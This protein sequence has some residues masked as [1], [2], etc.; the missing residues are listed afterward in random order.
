M[1]RALRALDRLIEREIFRLRARYQLS[2]DE[3]R[4]LYVS[5]EQVD[6]LVQEHRSARS[7][8]VAMDQAEADRV[9]QDFFQALERI[10]DVRWNR[11]C[12]VHAL[13]PLEKAL[14]FLA[15]APELDLKYETLL[16]YLNNDITRK[17]PTVDLARRVLGSTSRD[18]DAV[19]ASVASG[20]RLTRLHIIDPI[21]APSGSPSTLQAGF[22]LHRSAVRF[23]AG[24][25][26]HGADAEATAGRPAVAM[27]ATHAR[28]MSRPDAPVLLLAASGAE[29][30]DEFA[31]ALADTMG[32]P[33]RRFSLGGSGTHAERQREA[34]ALALEQ[35]LVPCV[36][37]VD[38]PSTIAD[39]ERREEPG[40]GLLADFGAPLLIRIGAG[41]AWRSLLN[42]R[43]TLKLTLRE[44]DFDEREALWAHACE[45][46]GLTLADE[47]VA[48][49]ADRYALSA[50]QIANATRTACDMAWIE[51]LDS[52]SAA[53]LHASARAESSATIG[54]LGRLVDSRH[55]W[56]DLIVHPDTL[57]RL[58]DV[59][60]AI[61]CRH[62][63]YGAWGFGA[64][65]ATGIGIK[66][67][68]A[69]PS[70]TGK[71]MA[72]GIVARELGLDL[73]R[74]DLAAMVS[75][76][77]GETEKNLNRVFD[78]ARAG[79]AMIFFDEAD[80][81]FGKRS[82]V[83]DAHDRYANIEVSY[84]LQK[85]EAHDGAVVL[86]TNLKRNIDDAFAR[87]L[88]Y[89]VE[90]PSP[91]ATER[92][93]L[94]R[95]MIPPAAPLDPDIDL[96]FLARQFEL[97]GGD[98]RNVVLEAAFLAA[99]SAAPIG[100][101]ELVWSLSRQLTKEGKMASSSAFQGYLPLLREIAKGAGG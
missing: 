10:V 67:L 48:A 20:A 27:V 61:R 51:G 32:L 74:I 56:E 72:A 37:L 1:S 31:A 47:E 42:G 40:D 21:A 52:V 87:R 65:D 34:S 62:I 28:L 35:R 75:K 8:H 101:R 9:T 100:M 73:Y 92:E 33:L 78:A 82:E 23:L 45:A 88:N 18:G 98:I 12:E 85:L 63:V 19:G 94:W 29:P 66:V 76:W 4:G 71:T 6:R 83:K 41:E 80:A 59:A 93:R 53:L 38:C 89:V 91:D 95:A 15:F 81:L 57:R 84:L 77:I 86:A 24:E 16:A 39:A 79:N 5:D 14:V 26:L 7:A 96:P 60:A 11:L 13:S 30:S 97:T 25:D 22:V 90:F 50:R 58:K 3:F 54:N 46:Q 55:R 49:L 70:G 99:R 17:W 43:R 68:F 64:R 44:P 69:G 2:L 36:I